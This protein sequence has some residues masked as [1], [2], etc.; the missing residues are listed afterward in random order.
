MFNLKNY[1]NHKYRNV[2]HKLDHTMYA[3]DRKLNPEQF[4]EGGFIVVTPV[5]NMEDSNVI[6]VGSGSIVSNSETIKEYEDGQYLR[7]VGNVS[8]TNRGGKWY[9]WAFA[10]TDS[11]NDN[12]PLYTYSHDNVV[13]VSDSVVNIKKAIFDECYSHCV[14]K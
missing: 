6:S 2:K 12:N 3:I 10:N 11:L 5:V 4:Y 8:I 14:I 13:Y 9:L 1:L 7:I